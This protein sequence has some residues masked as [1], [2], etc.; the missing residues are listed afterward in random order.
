M[1][2]RLRYMLLLLVALAGTFSVSG[3]VSMPD[4]VCV[5]AIKNYWVTDTPGSV[6]TWTINGATQTETSSLITVQ[7]DT[8]GTYTITVQELSADGCLGDVQSGEVI[9]S[10]N[11]LVSVALLADPN[12]VCFGESVL[13]T[14]TATNGGT[15]PVFSWFVDQGSGFTMVQT[16]PGNTYTYPPLNGDQVYVMLESDETCATG[17]PANSEIILMQV[18]PLLPVTVSIDALPS[19]ICEGTEIT[20]TTTSGNGGP[21]PVFSWFVDQGL[22]FVQV[23]SGADDFYTFIPNGGEIVYVEL[24][25]DIN[26]GSGN[27]AQSSQI[28]ID[29]TPLLQP[30]VT[31][32]ADNGDVCAG[33]E[34]TFTALPVNGGVNPVFEWYVDGG[35]VPG[36]TTST[37][38]YIP[39]NGDQVEAVLIS[40]ETCVVP[41]PVTSNTIVVNVNQPAIVTVGIS[42]ENNP[43]CAGTEVLFTATYS[44][45]GLN[46]QF[47][48]FLNGNPVG[49]NQDTYLFT[50]VDGDEIQLVL[51]SDAECV[52]GNPAT[53][54]LITMQVSD[55]LLVDVNISVVSTNV[56]AG[57]EVLVLADLVNQGINPD[58]RWY[59]NGNELIGENS[60]SLT[61]TP[62]NGDELYVILDSDETCTIND[63]A[64][65]NILEFIVQEIPMLTA[66]GT[67]PIIC[68]DDGII[69]FTFT[70]VPDG[71]YDITYDGGTFTAVEVIS[72]SATVIAPAGIYNNLSITVGVCTSLEVVNITITPANNPT[73]AAVGTDPLNCGDDGIIAFTFTNV[74]DGL[75]DITYNGGTFTAV[76]V[77][78]GSA[79]VIAPAGIY[80]NLSITVGVCTS[81]EVVNITITELIGASITDILYSDA[82]CGISNGSISIIASGGNTP[83]QYKVE[84]GITP[85]TWQTEN[86]FENLASG[87]YTVLVLDANGCET[88]WPL[89]IVINDLP[90]PV[91]IN[92]ETTPATNGLPNGE[93][94]IIAAGGLAPLEY[95]VNGTDWYPLNEFNG[96]AADVYTAYVRDA[97]GCVVTQE[98][99][100]SNSVVAEV[101]VSAQEVESCLN[102]PIELPVFSEN[103]IDVVS[104]TLVLTFDDAMVSYLNLV[105]VHPL[106]EAISPPSIELAA[107]QITIRYS[108]APGSVSLPTNA[109]LFGILFNGMNP[110]NVNFNWSFDECLILSAE[111]YE[112]PKSL[113]PGSVEI[114]PAPALQVYAGGTFCEGD[115]TIFRA[116][117]QDAQLLNYVWTRPDGSLFNNSELVLNPLQIGD[118][119]VYNFMATNPEGCSVT[120]TISLVVNPGAFVNISDTD[121]LCA[122]T[123][124]FLDAGSGFE[125]YLWQDGSNLQ[126]YTATEAGE[127]RVEV[128]NSY[129]CEGSS[130]VWL[131]PCTL[132]L[133][134]P[135]AFTPNGDRINDVFKPVLLGDITPSR[136][137]MQIYNK[138]GELVYE[139]SDYSAGW[140]GF[141][142]GS[143]APAGVYAFVINFEV[144]GYINVTV[145]SPVRGSVTLIR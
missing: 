10:D 16:G 84:D 76:E 38:A 130:S 59:L 39:N 50:P 66:T 116:V 101:L 86:L 36:A 58:I 82:T 55:Q 89:S 61:F 14:A 2:K 18:D 143:L 103:F 23:Q 120:E 92:I 87:S 28:T 134:M 31:I 127:Y 6:Y 8:P 91:I 30:S 11:L 142:K 19:V 113:V 105:N 35:L 49:A 135:N 21:N 96:L 131:V 37:Y 52:S 125:T 136:F 138:W 3:Q 109:Q 139:T 65:S 34:V 79:T 4:N 73:L 48:W 67:N 81:L 74:P 137:L 41:G 51:L 140:N 123:M 107:G 104:F 53:S 75:Y 72:G 5:G 118:N 132:E 97:R 145:K 121:S 27:P 44:N 46:P 110:G 111:G 112:I 95:S 22:G 117:S 122:G 45:E 129:G 68:G 141:V 43:V 128:V 29:V 9:V 119:G 85:G 60:L 15:N 26:C 144:P 64:T 77:I 99:T 98:F 133:T 83:L 71:L 126:T 70:N 7:W 63:P 100:I 124:H 32:T 42:P 62:D 57:T 94:R 114:L 69:A 115:S 56:C 47:Q 93:A 102:V 78:S 54:N 88:T 24:F 108:A 25:S 17:S 13:F 80:N 40:D 12:P 106:L 33:T 1:F 90:L 20:L